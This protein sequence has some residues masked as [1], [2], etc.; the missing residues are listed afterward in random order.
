MRIGICQA[1][2]PMSD[3]CGLERCQATRRMSNRYGQQV[4]YWPC[5]LLSNNADE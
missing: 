2:T 4:F 1:T 3:Y 5:A